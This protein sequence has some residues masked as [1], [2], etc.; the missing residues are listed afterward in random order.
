[1]IGPQRPHRQE[2][3]TCWVQGPTPGGFQKLWFVASSCSCCLLGPWLRHPRGHTCEKEWAQWHSDQSSCYYLPFT[4]VRYM[5]YYWALNIYWYRIIEP[6]KILDCW[7]FQR[8]AFPN[9]GGICRWSLFVGIAAL[10]LPLAGRR[11]RISLQ[12]DPFASRAWCH[13]CEPVSVEGS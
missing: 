10:S 9:L 7:A 1:M 13:C 12:V 5:L 11:A 3:A 2:D 4:N 8:L 6:V